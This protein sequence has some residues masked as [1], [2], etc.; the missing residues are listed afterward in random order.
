MLKVMRTREALFSDV[1]GDEWIAYPAETVRKACSKLCSP[2]M[3]QDCWGEFEA[4]GEME[5]MSL[6]VELAL[7]DEEPEYISI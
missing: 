7:S 3:A 4:G 1:L 5:C 2:E 6:F